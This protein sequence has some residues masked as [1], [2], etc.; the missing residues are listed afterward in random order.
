MVEPT[1]LAPGRKPSDE[2]KQQLKDDAAFYYD[3]AKFEVQ[4]IAQRNQI[5][6]VFQ[7]ML[8][9]ALGVAIGKEELF[10]PLWLLMA[11]GITACL[12]WLYLNALTRSL[13]CKAMEELEKVDPRVAI[14]LSARASSK[15]LSLGSVSKI[16]A[17]GFPSLVLLTWLVL[18]YFYGFAGA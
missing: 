18:L 1:F 8:F 17:F 9:A 15:L 7:S 6:L 12:L 3:L 4:A 5:L 13:E 16:V 11:L 2:Q 10:F 14:V